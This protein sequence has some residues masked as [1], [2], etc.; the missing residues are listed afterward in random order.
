MDDMNDFRSWGL[1]FRYDDQLKTM[2][3]MNNSELWAQGFRSYE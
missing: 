3:G 2:D 1:G